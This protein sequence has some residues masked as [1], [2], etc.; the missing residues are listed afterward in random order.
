MPGQAWEGVVIATDYTRFWIH[1][2]CEERAGFRIE[3]VVLRHRDR[4]VGP[5]QIDIFQNL[6]EGLGFPIDNLVSVPQPSDCG[7]K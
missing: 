2:E 1:Y 4:V 6:M 5:G 7:M 3:T